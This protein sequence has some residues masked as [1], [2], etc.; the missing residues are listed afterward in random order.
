[1]APVVEKATICILWSRFVTSSTFSVEK[2]I[3]REHRFTTAD[4]VPKTDEIGV[5][6]EKQTMA[7][8]GDERVVTF[9]RDQNE[10]LARRA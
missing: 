10:W 7:K 9:P 1:M 3:P 8:Q 4:Y 2:L 5:P 6:L